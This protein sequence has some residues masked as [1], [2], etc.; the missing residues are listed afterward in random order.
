[1]VDAEGTITIQ[2]PNYTCSVRRDLHLDIQA[3]DV[4]Y[5][6]NDERTDFVEDLYIYRPLW[7][8]DPDDPEDVKMEALIGATIDA[9]TGGFYYTGNGTRVK[10]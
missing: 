8:V 5:I 7:P 9:I 1:M 2:L 3:D 10:V 6:W 4:L